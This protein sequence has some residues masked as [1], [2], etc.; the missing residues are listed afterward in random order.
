MEEDEKN[1]S[2]KLLYI[3]AFILIFGTVIT[4]LPF[5]VVSKMDNNTTKPAQQ[6]TQQQVQPTA[7][8]DNSQVTPSPSSYIE[9]RGT[10][11]CTSDCSGH[12][13]GWEWAAEKEICDP[14]YDNGNS[15]SFN[16]GVRAWAEENCAYSEDGYPI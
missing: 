14:E 15:E 1:R 11:D 16:E 4:F 5:V 7:P 10:D 3:S 9:A 12:E 13:A 6:T 8:L 2:L